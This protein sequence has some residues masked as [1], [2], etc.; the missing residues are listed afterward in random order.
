MK[1]WYILHHPERL[2]VSLQ[3]GLERLGV[4]YFMPTIQE[5]SQRCD[6]PSLRPKRPKPLF[7]C[8]MFIHVDPEETHTSKISRLNGAARFLRFG[9]FFYT[10][11]QS[12][13]DAM[14]FIEFKMIYKDENCFMCVNPPP[15]LLKKMQYI[16]KMQLPEN[17]VAA[18]NALLQLPKRLLGLTA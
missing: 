17:R 3:D 2:Y 5:Y 9:E 16:Y 15:E 7:P 11:Q 13:I 12:D 18:L 6:R 8:Y 4:E 10:I 14:K 1:K